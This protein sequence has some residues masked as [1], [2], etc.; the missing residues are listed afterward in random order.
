M[1]KNC[2]TRPPPKGN[3]EELLYLASA[4]GK[5]KENCSSWLPPKGKMKKNCSTRPHLGT[6]MTISIQNI[7]F[8]KKEDST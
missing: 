5:M 4:K 1:K 8:G 3:E 2:S 6:A 7:G